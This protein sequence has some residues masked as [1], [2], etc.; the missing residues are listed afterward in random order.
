MSDV[1]MGVWYTHWSRFVPPSVL[2][3]IYKNP[4][5]W[6]HLLEEEVSLEA[7]GDLHLVKVTRPPGYLGQCRV[8]CFD[9]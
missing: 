5:D 6:Q 9:I 2:V 1:S 3:R 7:N 4:K 8:S